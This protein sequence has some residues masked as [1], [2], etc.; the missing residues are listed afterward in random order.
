M[1]YRYMVLDSQS[2][3]VARA[4]LE[5]HPKAQVWQI[6]ILDGDVDAVLNHELLQ[7]LSMDEDHPGMVG[8][9][10]RARGDMV[11]LEPIRALGEEARQNLRVQ[12]G[13]ETYVYTLGLDGR[14]NGRIPVNVHDL[15]CGGV[16]FF[17]V[18]ELERG[19]LLEIVI[20]ITEQPAILKIQV[21]R[22]RPS[23]SKV[24]LYAAKFVE[25]THDEEKLVREAVFS[26]QIK[27]SNKRTSKSSEE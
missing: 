11:E 4:I 15:S 24:P 13:F 17:S 21:L 5:N 10:I 25:L 6:Q 27:N 8:R 16:A 20:S 14:A 2:I 23:P 18:R 22:L 12:V 7:L 3:P 1:A 19:Q 9:V 26:Q